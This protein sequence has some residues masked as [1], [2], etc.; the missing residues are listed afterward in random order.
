MKRE[1][2]IKKILEEYEYSKL[3]GFANIVIVVE[4]ALNIYYINDT[5]YGFQ[6]DAFDCAFDDLADI[7][8]ELYDEMQGEILDIRIE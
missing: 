8:E 4:T 5:E 3:K 1:E 7:A 6:C 2:F